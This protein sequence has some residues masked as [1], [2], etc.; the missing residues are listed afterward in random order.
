MYDTN[1]NLKKNIDKFNKHIFWGFK[2]HLLKKL[3]S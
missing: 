3:F 2:I 1:E